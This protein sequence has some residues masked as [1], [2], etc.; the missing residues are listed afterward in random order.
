MRRTGLI[1]IVGCFALLLAACGGNSVEPSPAPTLA[2]DDSDASPVVGDPNADDGE[3]ETGIEFPFGTP[4]PEEEESGE[5][6]APTLAA[7]GAPIDPTAVAT[8]APF[9]GLDISADEIGQPGE[10]QFNSAEETEEAFAADSGIADPATVIF[11]KVTVIRSGGIDGSDL[12]IEIFQDGRVLRDGNPSTT[13]TPQQVMDLDALLDEIRIFSMSGQFAATFPRQD[14]YIYVIN[15]DQ[16]DRSISHRADDTYIP[17]EL[18]RVV[19][20]AQEAVFGAPP[21]PNN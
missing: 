8:L 11:D 9:G 12:T 6:L 14:D 17:G 16:A 18:T 7:L 13:L 20:F 10:A 5:L 3:D 21:M 15:V 19:Q 1:L 4:I 2:N